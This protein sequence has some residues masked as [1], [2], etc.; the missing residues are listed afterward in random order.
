MQHPTRC[1]ITGCEGFLGSHL[2]DFLVA[3]GLVVYGTVYED[4]GN[5]KHLDGKMTM[6]P[7]DLEDRQRVEA[8]VKESSP[9]LVFHLAAQSFVT[10]SWL[11]PELTLRTNVLGTFNL[12]EALRQHGHPSVVEILG[13]S[14]VYGPSSLSEMPLGEGHE[15]R[16][17]SMYAVSKVTEDVLG[18]FYWK[19]YGLPILR[20]R[21][22]NMT[23]P[24]KIADA[25]SDFARGIAEVEKGQREVLEVG[26][27]DAVR[28]ITDGRDA[29]QALWTLAQ[30]GEP[31]ETY[32]LCSGQGR[33]LREILEQILSLAKGK[34][35]VEVSSEKLRP[36]DDPIYIGNNAKLLELGWKPQI[37]FVQTLQDSL[38]YWREWVQ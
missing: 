34:I 27:L 33:T 8:V 32:N 2:A 25:V 6:V 7:L 17:T 14:A 22:F 1:L 31:G 36:Y 35:E 5:L 4:T 9:D 10:V 23:G 15:F 24:R 30:K 20:V 11:D 3:K 26:N 37:P 13:S 16:P 19:V 12:L 38:D 28:D 18:Y 21:P 29:V